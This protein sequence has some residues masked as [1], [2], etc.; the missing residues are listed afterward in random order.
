MEH[1]SFNFLK[2]RTTPLTIMS[3]LT[4]N[5][6]AAT[7]GVLLKVV[8]LKILQISQENTRVGVPL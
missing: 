8:L 7:A 3:Y 6:E 5:S 4:R 2:H 1:F